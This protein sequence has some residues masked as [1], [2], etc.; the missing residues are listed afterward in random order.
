MN[1]FFNKIE[2]WIL[3][4]CLCLFTVMMMLM[5][6]GTGFT[7]AGRS[8]S[9][10]HVLTYSENKLTWDAAM[11]IL[12]DGSA[13][14][15]LFLPAY[16]GTQS[17][18]GESIF[19]PGT[20]NTCFV[21]LENTVAGPITYTAVLYEIKSDPDL[22]ITA[23]MAGETFT[24]SGSYVLPEGVQA[25]QVIQAVTGSV[26]AK[27]HQDLDVNWVWDFYVDDAQDV[28]DTYLGD[29]DHSDEVTIG[30]YIT[31]HDDAGYVKPDLP[32]QTGDNSPVAMYLTLAG[33]SLVVLILLVWDRRR[34]RN[35]ETA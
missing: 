16:Q 13:E 24:E 21:R 14:L 9:P 1:K 26:P 19:A 5:P 12:P 29:K 31:V 15:D 8:Q 34:E 3:P 30:L 10:D 17:A 6:I 23:S 27:Q 2:G 20:E 32:P 25:H 28:L 18:D 22:P 35:S 7:Y 4:V 11:N 33:V